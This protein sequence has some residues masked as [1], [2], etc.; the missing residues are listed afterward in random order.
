MGFAV[1]VGMSFVLTGNVSEWFLIPMALLAAAGM[2]DLSR[3]AEHEA[4]GGPVVRVL[5]GCR[6]HGWAGVLVLVVLLA[7]AVTG[8]VLGQ[9]VTFIAGYVIWAMLS[10]SCIPIWQYALGRARGRIEAPAEQGRRR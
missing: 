2:R 9:P 8:A 3:V 1:V 10:A 5:R 7:L 4:L 6:R